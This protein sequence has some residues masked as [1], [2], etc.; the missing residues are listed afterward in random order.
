MMTHT[1]KI[2]NVLGGLLMVATL[3]MGGMAC[4][5][6]R[7]RVVSEK[8][9]DKA[10]EAAERA[11]EATKT[12]DMD[13]ARDEVKEAGKEIGKANDKLAD[14]SA[15][16]MGARAEVGKEVAEGRREVG[17]AYASVRDDMRALNAKNADFAAAK[18][19]VIAQTERHLAMR[20]Q[21]ELALPSRMTA[22]TNEDLRKK[23]NDLDADYREATS[24]VERLKKATAANW[25]K[26]RDDVLD[27]V[28]D[29]DKK[30]VDVKKSFE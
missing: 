15:D 7:D 1:T 18:D 23:V 8:A 25:E 21:E 4:D 19:K 16:V 20:R 27:A 24:A 29:Y 5:N 6:D 2:K 30:V 9:I 22:A 17:D 3:G 11:R 14:E 12:D 28:V 13:K 10:D 26:M